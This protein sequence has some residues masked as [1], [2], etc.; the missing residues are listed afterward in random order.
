MDFWT[1]ISSARLFAA[2]FGYK[3]GNNRAVARLHNNE[4][5]GVDFVQFETLISRTR[6]TI[7][8]KK[9]VRK[10]LLRQQ[11]DFFSILFALTMNAKNQNLIR[12][13]AAS[14]GKNVQSISDILRNDSPHCSMNFFGN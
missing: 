13:L 9:M 6:L 2:S 7:W 12:Y 1:K 8:A 5:N 11:I 14:N 3:N 10:L 4:R